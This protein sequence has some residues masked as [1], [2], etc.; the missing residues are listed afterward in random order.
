MTSD[1]PL[2]P[3]L[4]IDIGGT[5]MAVGVVGPDGRVLVA[6]RCPTPA[7]GLQSALDG[8]TDS[9]LTSFQ[10][11][12]EAEPLVGVGI[13]CGGPMDWARGEVSPLNI[14]SWR[15]YPLLA[16]TRERFPDLP[17]RLHGDALCFVAAEHWLGAGRGYADLL[18]MV[19]STGV[20]GG[21]ILDGQLR[22]GPTGNAGH[23]GHM[24]VEPDGPLCGCGGHGCLEAVARGPRLVEWALAHGWTGAPS[25]GAP[26]SEPAESLPANSGPA[27]FAPDGRALLASARAGDHIAI[28]AFARAGQ[29]V[30]VAVAGAAAVLDFHHVVIGGGIASAGDLLFGPLRAELAARARLDFLADLTVQPS[31]LGEHAG[32]VGA[33]AL[34]CCGDRYWPEPSTG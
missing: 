18:G 17:V 33:A 12:A 20:G 24:I 23:I 32:L 31:G 25:S 4:A 5:K 7:D 16:K 3:V 9:V 27:Q 34:I 10:A 22:G 2:G 6:D 28:K 11:G 8:V 26:D 13:A 15:S 29:A 14:P 30:A 1:L 19:V 21:V